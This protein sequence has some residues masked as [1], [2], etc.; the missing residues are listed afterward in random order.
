M[1]SSILSALKRG[2]QHT[3]FELFYAGFKAPSRDLSSQIGTIDW[4]SNTKIEIIYQVGQRR[5]NRDVT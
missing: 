3:I 1:E 5:G 4:L 2:P